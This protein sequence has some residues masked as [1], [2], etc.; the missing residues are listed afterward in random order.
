LENTR[1]GSPLIG[2]SG[3]SNR[4]TIEPQESLVDRRRFIIGGAIT[5]AITSAGFLEDAEASSPSTSEDAGESERFLEID[6]MRYAYRQFT[7]PGGKPPIVL[8]HHY[9]DF[10][11][12]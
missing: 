6:G 8:L 10:M 12:G 11:E 3:K 4:Q 2:E 5:A 1:L 9:V 7:Q